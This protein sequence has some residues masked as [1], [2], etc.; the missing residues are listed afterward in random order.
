[1]ADFRP[2]PEEAN[3]VK[4]DWIGM[5]IDLD[6]FREDFIRIFLGGK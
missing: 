3:E 6:R 2:K 1:M 4:K 5:K